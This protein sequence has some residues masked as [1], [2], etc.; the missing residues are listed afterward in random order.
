VNLLQNRILVAGGLAT[1][2]LAA[3]AV[4]LAG[5]MLFVALDVAGWAHAERAGASLEDRL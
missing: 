1:R 2:R 5:V 3:I 4:L